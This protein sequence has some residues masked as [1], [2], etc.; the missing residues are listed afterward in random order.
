[1]CRLDTRSKGSYFICAVYTCVLALYHKT[2]ART[3]R[4]AAGCLTPSFIKSHQI[5]SRTQCCMLRNCD[6][7]KHRDADYDSSGLDDELDFDL[8]ESSSLLGDDRILIFSD[9]QNG[10]DSRDPGSEHF[11]TSGTKP[12]DHI[13]DAIPP[14]NSAVDDIDATGDE[15]G[16]NLGKSSDRYAL[17]APL[18]SLSAGVGNSSFVQASSTQ[19]RGN[20]GKNA[21]YAQLQRTMVFLKSFISKEKPLMYESIDSFVRSLDG[22]LSRKSSLGLDTDMRGAVS[23]YHTLEA[24]IQHDLSDIMSRCQNGLNAKVSEGR[25][26]L[27]GLTKS[28]GMHGSE[29]MPDLNLLI[30]QLVDEYIDTENVHRLSVMSS[31]TSWLRYKFISTVDSIIPLRPMQNIV[32]LVS[33]LHKSIGSIISRLTLD[34]TNAE[35]FTEGSLYRYYEMRKAYI[36]T[37]SI[38]S[39]ENRP[40]SP[41]LN[42]QWRLTFLGTGARRPTKTRLTSSILFSRADAPLWLFD[43]GEGAFSSIWDAGHSPLR[44]KR[45]F[46]THLHGDHCY[47]LFSFLSTLSPT[48]ALEIYGPRG[49]SKFIA[50]VLASSSKS[51]SLGQFIVNE[52]VKS[53]HVLKEPEMPF[54]LRYIYPNSRMQYV[55]HED[56]ICIVRAAPLVHSIN[57]VGYVVEE[58]VTEDARCDK[59]GGDT[60]ECSV[61]GRKVVICQDTSDSRL[62]QPL[63]MDADVL[64]HESTINPPTN[65]GSEMLLRLVRNARGG[66]VTRTLLRRVDEVLQTEEMKFQLYHTTTE[67]VRHHYYRNLHLLRDSMQRY[68]LLE[69]AW[70]EVVESTNQDLCDTS[71]NSLTPQ[72]SDKCWKSLVKRL[73]ALLRLYGAA[74]SMSRV[75]SKLDGLVDLMSGLRQTC[76]QG[77]AMPK[78]RIMQGNIRSLAIEI[79]EDSGFTVDHKSGDPGASTKLSRDL[80]R[81]APLIFRYWHDIIGPT[82]PIRESG[83][84]GRHEWERLYNEYA[85]FSGH[86]T[87][88]QAGDFAARTRARKLILTHFSQNTPDGV[89]RDTVLTMA[90]IVHSALRGYYRRRNDSYVTPVTIGAAWDMF[91]ITL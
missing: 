49:L 13:V 54:K 82:V 12:V 61:P 9:Q 15:H 29:C 33:S 28:L 72:S 68:E 20:L 18:S 25:T 78:S 19:K 88:L 50:D 83:V 35:L 51:Q 10:S 91:T 57:T 27:R 40:L 52:F 55:A 8:N 36:H 23:R 31:V 63:A 32:S 80:D 66:N 34:D 21:I 14:G 85:K 5:L 41:P 6:F 56:S 46:I 4:H 87:C 38:W 60:P 1:M 26:V 62:L 47:G 77:G 7:A 11:D 22:N 79:L 3:L 16:T 71:S 65:S 89:D 30:D 86:S 37:P 44:V 59:S 84:Y 58:K 73:N 67:N 48:G 64:I 24:S 45:I 69:G 43:C 75:V 90:R 2:D 53:H 42:G 39:K 17:G 74:H 76:H 70:S 81:L